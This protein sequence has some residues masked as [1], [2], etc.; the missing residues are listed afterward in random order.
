MARPPALR[1]EATRQKCVLSTGCGLDSHKAPSGSVPKE[2]LCTYGW[3]D[4]RVYLGQKSGSRVSGCN[5]EL[6]E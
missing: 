6:K 4:S 3:M 2:R 1:G 5:G